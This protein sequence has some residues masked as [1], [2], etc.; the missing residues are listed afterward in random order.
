MTKLSHPPLTQAE[1]VAQFRL[2][3]IGSLLAS[4]PEQGALSPQLSKLA[5]KSYHHPISGKSVDY[6]IATLERWYYQA[7][8]NDDAILATLCPQ[9]RNDKGAHKAMNQAVCEAL[10]RQYAAHD[11]WSVQ[12][13]Y[14]NLLVRIEKED[15][16]ANKPSYSSVLRYMKAHELHRKSKRHRTNSP[17][18]KK[19]AR[20]KAQREIRSF[21]VDHANG[22]WHLDF[23]HGSLKV[24]NRHGEWVKPLLLAIMDDSSRLICHLQWYYSEDTET[25]VHGFCQALQKR[26]LPR[27]LLSDNGSA[28]ISD[29]FTRGLL[30]LGID[31]KKTL[32]YS[33]YQN[34]K[35]E[36][37]WA[38]IEGR[39]LAMLEH[40]ENLTLRQLN[41]MTQIWVEG[42]YHQKKHAALQGQTPIECYLKR[43]NVARSCPDSETLHKAFRRQAK[44][45]QRRSDG[46][47]SLQGKRFEIPDQY[48]GLSSITLRYA[49][50]NLSRIDM[51]DPD[52]GLTLSTLYPVNKSANASG[53]RRQRYSKQHAQAQTTTC[54]EPSPLLD[55]LQKEYAAT[56]LPQAYIAKDEIGEPQ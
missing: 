28:M 24:L 20:R 52:S 6:S 12:L 45:K 17:G 48:H 33:A 4:P 25:L 15:L 40:Q 43:H 23:H 29:E 10:N 31:H 41:D 26:S 14:D 32:P 44:R 19:A 42:D 37:F 9:T 55:K 22:L 50:W 56:G 38:N 30:T 46:T 36:T 1:Q 27:S 54:H 47:I 51:I 16:Q 8:N 21:E 34:G 7:K 18:A 49:A 39:L 35:Q 5:E 53:Q 2:S 13:H 11:S 3:I